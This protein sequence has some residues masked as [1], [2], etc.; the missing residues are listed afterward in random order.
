MSTTASLAALVDGMPDDAATRELLRC[1]GCA[2]WV[3]DMIAA[4]PFVD[5][6]A[7]HAAATLLWGV[8]TEAEVLEALAHHPEIGS[9]LAALRQK[10]ASTA[11]WSG[12]EQAQVA[13]ADEATLVALRDGNLAYRAKFG[14]LFVICATGKSAAQMLEALRDRLANDRATEIANAAREQGAITHLRLDK[15]VAASA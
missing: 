7:V 8:A 11:T 14:F 12:N 4:R 15:L 6:A 13:A 10:F 2:R 9:D 5:D 3:R 1:C